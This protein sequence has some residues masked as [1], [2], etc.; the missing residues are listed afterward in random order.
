MKP[1]IPDTPYLEFKMLRNTMVY[2]GTAQTVTIPSDMRM[3]KLER[4]EHNPHRPVTIGSAAAQAL[5][6]IFY[7]DTVHRIELKNERPV[8]PK[9]MPGMSD[10]YHEKLCD[11]AYER[12]AQAKVFND[13]IR[14]R[15]YSYVQNGTME[16]VSDPFAGEEEV[17]GLAELAEI[18]KAE[19]EEAEAASEPATAPQAKP[20]KPAKTKE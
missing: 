17:E 11:Q 1:N 14:K 3:E 9:K 6:P 18:K 19:Q 2:L 20:P 8:I 15:V 7:M 16:L 12:A 4:V 13:E 5:R 10:A